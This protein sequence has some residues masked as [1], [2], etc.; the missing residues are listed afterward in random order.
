MK[1]CAH[2]TLFCIAATRVIAQDIYEVHMLDILPAGEDYAPVPIKDAFVM[3][4][5]RDNGGVMDN[6]VATSWKPLSDLYLVPFEQGRPRSPRLLTPTV[7]T[8]VNEGPAT[9]SA[10][11]HVICYTRN[12][13]LP[14]KRSR[15]RRSGA[16]LGLFFATYVDG[17]WGAPEPFEHNDPSY[18]LMH[19][20]FGPGEDLL[21]FASDMPGGYGGMD[22]YVCRRT[23]DGWSAPENLGMEVNGPGNEA[24]PRHGNGSLYFSSDRP[25]IY[26]G[27]DIY[28][29]HLQGGIWE[30]PVALPEPVNGPGN[31]LGFAEMTDHR[32]ALFSSDR[33]GVDRI[34]MAHRTVPKF[35]DC[36]PQRYHEL[37]YA[38][39]AR[40]HAATARLPLDHAWDLGDGTI[41]RG[42]TVRHC[43]ADTGTYHVRSILVDRRTGAHFQTLR[44]HSMHVRHSEQAFILSADTIRTGRALIMDPGNSNVP[45]IAGAAFHWDMGDGN[46]LTGSPVQHQFRKAGTYL[47]RLDIL[48]PPDA[49]DVI[50]NRCNSKMV[51]VLDRYREHE[52]MAVTVTYQNAMVQARKKEYVLLPYDDL[53]IDPWEDDEMHFTVRLLTS[54]ERLSLDDPRFAGILQHHN[55]VER[56]D[57]ISAAYTYSVGQTNDPDELYAIFQLVKDLEFIDAEVFTLRME[58]LVDL[59]KLDLDIVQDLDHT[60]LRTDLILFAY[61]SA[62]ISAGSQ[63][64]L[65]RVY[66]LMLQY[67]E[68]HLVVEAHTDDIGNSNY[69]LDLSQRRA[70]SVIAYLA[71]LG[72]DAGRMV[73]VGHGKNQPI[74]TNDTEEGRQQNRRVEFRLSSMEDPQALGSAR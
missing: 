61:K 28:R 68:L 62:E 15:V 57:P 60:K 74:A 38:F 50:R 10:D 18:S 45:G 16:Q 46:L 24:Y 33:S 12:Q 51:V 14:K 44:N 67:P 69:N 20:T 49:H 13:P 25:G 36:T 19:P 35:R 42:D 39:N 22:L 2:I 64:A 17:Q 4:S 23:P 11:G 31:D 6:R 48:L 70:Q 72:L 40:K 34:Y 52:D 30:P 8:Q 41:A 37:C 3:C 63:D 59:S 21:Y 26:G 9:F 1:R 43:Y 71:G 55:V 5:V 53:G 7:T 29:T 65:D 73:P 32:K 66:R 54:R 47:V 27:W 58:Q 56:Y